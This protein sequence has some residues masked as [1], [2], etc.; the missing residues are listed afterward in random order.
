TKARRKLFFMDTCESGEAD[1]GRGAISSL[2]TTKTIRSR[3]ARGFKSSSGQRSYLFQKDRYI[4]NNL[5]RRSGTIV[6]S[7]SLGGEYSYERDDFQNGLFT[8]ALIAALGGAADANY[9]AKVDTYELRRYLRKTVSSWSNGMQ[10]PT[11]DRDN[12]SQLISLP[13]LRR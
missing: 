9:D 6:F 8:E 12:I 7:S 11:V 4:Y 5:L 10:N 13:V 2:N 3:A 1:E